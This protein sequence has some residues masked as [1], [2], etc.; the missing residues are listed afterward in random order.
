MALIK[1]RDSYSVAVQKFDDQ[2]KVLIGLLNN[3]FVI[4]REKQSANN[5]ASGINTLIE[6]TQEH[7]SDEEEAMASVDHPK[8]NEHKAIHGKLL[9]E[10]ITYKK[11]I[12][13]DD[14]KVVQEFYLF[15]RDWL[16]IHILEEDMKYQLFLATDMGTLSET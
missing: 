8:L 13:N 14:E 16:L 11:R 9:N 6:Y 3:I 1:W 4:A 10:V 7:F 5:L 12:D 2:H 15:L